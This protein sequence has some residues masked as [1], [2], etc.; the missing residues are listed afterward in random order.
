MRGLF[1]H[2]FDIVAINIAISYWINVN[3][4][5]SGKEREKEEKPWLG[6]RRR[7]HTAGRARVHPDLMKKE[8]RKRLILFISYQYKLV[9]DETSISS[10][11]KKERNGKYVLRIDSIDIQDLGF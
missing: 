4:W 2:N 7:S 9:P 3:G 10:G 6:R 5:L 11:G 1:D 8:R